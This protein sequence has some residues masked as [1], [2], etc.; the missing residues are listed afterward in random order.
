MQMRPHHHSMRVLAF[1][2]DLDRDCNTAVAGEM[3]AVSRER[4]RSV[5]P[6]Y[7]ASAE[8]MEAIADMLRSHSLRATVF[9]EGDTLLSLPDASVL[10]GQELACHGMGHEDLT[11]GHSG[12]VP[13]DDELRGIIRR[14]KEAV[15]SRCGI[16]PRGFRAPY[17]NIDPRAL[18]HLGEEGFSYD[19]SITA[20]VVDGSVTPWRLENGML[21]MPLARDKDSEG[22]TMDSYMWA[23]HEGRRPEEDYLGMLERFQAGALVMA[24]HSWHVVES[25][26]GGR[27]T[28]G[29]TA[30]QTEAIGRVLCRAQDL[31]FEVLALDE[32]ER[33]ISADR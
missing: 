14:S 12:L 30:A 4:G 1:T 22:R 8:G 26:R 20:P 16:A 31:G 27:R 19:S 24:T 5:P 11:G 3:A 28:K 25:V 23:M 29:D 32:L 15:S 6:R 7:S 13:D 17:L 18:A 9:A 33:R 2:V 10:K 21:E